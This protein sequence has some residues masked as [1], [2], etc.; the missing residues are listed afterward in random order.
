[1]NFQQ[2][3]Y[4]VAVDTYRHFV[5]AA[6]KCY[7]TQATLSMMIKKLEQELEIKIFDR[8]KQPV[9]PTEIGA[10]IIRQAKIILKEIGQIKELAKADQTIISGDLK[11]GIIPTLAP[12]LLPLFLNSFLVNYPM[13]KLEIHELT[14][15][16]IVARLERSDLDAGIVATP[17]GEASLKE[18]VLFYETFVV[19]ASENE[20]LMEKKFV[21][22]SDIDVN[23]LWLLQ[24]GHCMRTQ[25]LNLCALEKMDHN[26]RQLNFASGSIETMIRIVDIN[27]GITILPELSLQNMPAAQKKRIR[28]FQ[29]PDPVREI[30][31]VTHRHFVKEQIINALQIEILK[32]IPKKM[33]S[34]GLSLIHI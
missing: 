30:S 19:Y 31:L 33:Q 5:T 21:L 27:K 3:E 18:R 25:V 12:Y 7:V 16:E 26:S 22:S 13:V 28:Y 4:I 1:M 32:C 10:K 2:L 9:I 24:E 23:K 17:L 29:T 15:N 20:K 11:I 34:R 6:D 14:T 8:S